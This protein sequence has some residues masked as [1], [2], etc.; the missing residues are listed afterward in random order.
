MVVESVRKVLGNRALID[1]RS[2]AEREQ[3][4][5][6]GCETKN[7]CLK[8]VK[9]RLD[10]EVVTRTK[11]RALFRIVHR[12]RKLS[13]EPEKARA[14]PDRKSREQHFRIRRSPKLVPAAELLAQLDIVKNLAVK[15]DNVP[16][17]R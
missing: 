14:A 11:Q 4:L 17:V 10:A 6:L 9:K 3:A 15:N 5:D 16:P 7:A 12:K 13:V 2:D 8:R 1:A